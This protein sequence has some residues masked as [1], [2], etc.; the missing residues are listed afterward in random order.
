MTSYRVLASA[1]NIRSG[2]GVEY[3]SE[4]IFPN[5]EV[6]ES[7]DT[8]GWIPIS[9]QEELEGGGVRGYVGWGSAKY[10]EKYDAPTAPVKPSGEPPWLTIAR[11]ELGAKEIYG[12]QHNKR[13]VE[14][15][16]T[17][18]L[19]ATDDETPWCSSFVNWCII[20]A[21]L[22]GTNSAAA[23]SWANW[24]KSVP[25]ANA[26]LGDIVVFS[27][28]GG[29]HVGFYIS[30]DASAIRVLGGNQSDEVNIATF[31]RARFLSLRRPV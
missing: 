17:T 3:E 24:G 13:I 6:L 19:K 27:R 5:G 22:K 9:L 15:H 4:I 2:P 28:T 18:T 12:G 7:P 8:T 10:L 14:Y 1:L 25:L 21:G 16:Q 26:Q 29:N 31:S 23:I 30:H 11:G 20:K